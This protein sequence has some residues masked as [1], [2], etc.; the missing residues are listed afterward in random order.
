MTQAATDIA[1]ATARFSLAGQRV[2]LTGAAGIIG[3][4]FSAALVGAGA[5]VLLVDRE[6]ASLA[7]FAASLQLKSDTQKVHALAA[8]LADRTQDAVIVATAREAFGAPATGLVNNAASKGPDLRAFFAPD[9]EFSPEI[10]RDIFAINL[11]APFFL[12]VAFA[13]ELRKAG[14]PGS[15]VN[16]SSIY[17]HMSPD[18]RIYEGSNYLGGEIRSPA[19]YSASKAGVLGLTRHL[20]TLWGAEGIRV[21]SIAPGGVSSG[22]NGVFND[23]YSARIPMG[24][25][26]SSDDM[27]GA[28]IFLLSGASS[29]VTGQNWLVDGGLSAW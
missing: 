23:R 9:E 26:A 21:N 14:E 7:E 22:Q 25:M 13:R 16:L 6:A 5:S 17:G 29:Y 19:V 18:Q 24:R 8:D 20:A 10:W 15:I 3:R 27:V 11:E 1:D 2:I 28:L 4:T 12:A